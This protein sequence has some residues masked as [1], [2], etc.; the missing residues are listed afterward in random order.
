MRVADQL[1]HSWHNAI[2]LCGVCSRTFVCKLAH[3]AD[4][5]YFQFQQG[6]LCNHVLSVPFRFH[7]TAVDGGSD[8]N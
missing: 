3:C 4:A 8:S 6:L 1:P 5:P 7:P 2:R